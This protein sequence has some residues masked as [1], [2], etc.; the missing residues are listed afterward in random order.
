VSFIRLSKGYYHSDR[1]SCCSSRLFNLTDTRRT[2]QL[3][4][5]VGLELIG[6][7]GK[8]TLYLEMFGTEVHPRTGHEG[9]EGEKYSSTL[10]LTSALDGMS[11]QCHAP[12]SL[13]PGKTWYPLYRRLGGPQS[14]SGQGRKISSSL[15]FDPRTVQSVASRYTVWFNDSY[16]I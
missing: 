13:P 5:S 8:N 7:A 6:Q 16:L 15:E 9:P 4:Q 14:R 12:A 1:L 3:W 11:D 2:T 10:S